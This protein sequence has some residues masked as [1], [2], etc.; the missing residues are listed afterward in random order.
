M[1]KAKLEAKWQDLL[2]KTAKQDSI[3]KNYEGLMK[4]DR[5]IIRLRDERIARQTKYIERLKDAVV[6]LEGRLAN[7]Y[8]R[9]RELDDKNTDLS[10][11]LYRE[12]NK[13]TT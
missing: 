4:V 1:K 10:V 3:I 2:K 8:A 13:E 12:M 6:I 11:R 5:A 7:Q 9:I